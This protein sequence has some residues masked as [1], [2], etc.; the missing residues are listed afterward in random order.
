MFFFAQIAIAVPFCNSSSL[1]QRDFA[2]RSVGKAAIQER[3]DLPTGAGLFRGE[4]GGAGA[5]GN[6]LLDGPVYG[7]GGNIGKGSFGSLGAVGV[8]PHEF[9][10]H[11]TGTGRIGRECSAFLHP[12]FRRPGGGLGILIAV[13]QSAFLVIYAVI[14]ENNPKADDIRHFDYSELINR[15][16]GNESKLIPIWELAFPHQRKKQRRSKD[17]IERQQW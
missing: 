7:I 15:T 13:S 12:L 6:A 8:L 14:D 1:F 3:H 9:H 16:W 2:L 17:N 11:Q 4:R 10:R 5:I